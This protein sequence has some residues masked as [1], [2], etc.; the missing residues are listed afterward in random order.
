MKALVRRTY[1]SPDVLEIVDLPR[2]EPKPN[3]VLVQVHATSVTT[4]EWRFRA[5]EFPRGFWLIGRLMVGLFRPRNPL[6]GREFSG[7]VVAVGDAVTRFREGDEVFGATDAGAN[8]EYIAVPESAA[9]V[10]KPET[11]T[12]AE[13]VALPFGALTAVDFVRRGEVKRGE[14]VLIV[15]ASGGVGAYVVQYAKHVGAHVTAV[16]SAK[17]AELVRSLGADEVIDYRTQ[18]PAD[19]RDRYDVVF[20]VVGKTTLKRY[21][22]ALREGGRLVFIEGP[23]SAIVQSITTRWLPGPRVLFGVTPDTQ[24]GLR[25]LLDIVREGGIKPVIGHR[26]DMKNA[27]D[28]HRVVDG[29]HRQGAVVLRIRGAEPVS[30]PLRDV[31]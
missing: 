16:C 1:G 22:G 8:A 15:G 31:S 29:R 18:D 24:E 3:E 2:P 6:T 10:R 21:R 17:N 4:A 12:H 25:E 27:A 20:D 9:I 14:R 11:L 19:A 28:A 5:G 30:V 26:F 23:L 7:R 13:A